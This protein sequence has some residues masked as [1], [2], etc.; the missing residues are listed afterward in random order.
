MNPNRNE[1]EEIVRTVCNSHC[2][3]LCEMKVHVK[4]GRVIRIENNDDNDGATPRG[5]PRGRAYRQRLYAPDRLL[6]PL[7]RTGE[8]GRGEFA[9][10]SWDEAL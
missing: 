2:G 3:G 8:R 10:I 9:R 7:K 5:C 6:Y 1:T 4:D